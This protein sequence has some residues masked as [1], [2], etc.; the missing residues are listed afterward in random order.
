[1]GLS[2]QLVLRSRL[3]VRRQSQFLGGSGPEPLPC[4]APFAIPRPL[5]SNE[6]GGGVKVIVLIRVK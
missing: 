2:R 5:L 1:M 6:G 4:L 3:A